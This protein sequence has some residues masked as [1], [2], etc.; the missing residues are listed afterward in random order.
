M[1][2][3]L[4]S[5][6]HVVLVGIVGDKYPV[7]V[8]HEKQ[9]R[10]LTYKGHEKNFCMHV[11]MY[12]CIGTNSSNMKHNPSVDYCATAKP[13]VSFIDGAFSSLNE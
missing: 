4:Q 10:N 2:T 5:H 11:R 7:D 12:Y 9:K 6:N 1:R 8:I 13:L 3:T